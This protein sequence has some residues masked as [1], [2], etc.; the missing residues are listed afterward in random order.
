MNTNLGGDRRMLG[1]GDAAAYL[2][3]AKRTLA[4]TW[5][6]LGLKPSRIGGRLKYRVSDLERYIEEHRA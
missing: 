4:V 3:I 1:T 6:R 5:K 2:G